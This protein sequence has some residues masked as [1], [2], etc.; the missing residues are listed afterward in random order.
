[1]KKPI[2]YTLLLLLSIP[3]MAQKWSYYN[4]KNSNITSQM[5]TPSAANA[6]S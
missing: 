5:S 6:T 3:L 1:M 2:L 4:P